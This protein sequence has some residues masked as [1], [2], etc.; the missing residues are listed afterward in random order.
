MEFSMTVTS[1]GLVN[2]MLL[3]LAIAGVVLASMLLFAVLVA[4]WKVIKSVFKGG[5][6]WENLE[7]LILAITS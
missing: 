4:A 2:L 5:K 1:M 3:I 7:E 6:W